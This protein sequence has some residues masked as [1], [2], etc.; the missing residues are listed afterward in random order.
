MF[1]TGHRCVLMDQGIPWT[2]M[3]DK[4]RFARE[5]SWSTRC[6]ANDVS[7][8]TIERLSKSPKRA[9]CDRIFPPE[10]IHI[11]PP[12]RRGGRGGLA[13]QIRQMMP[14]VEAE[15]QSDNF[16]P[17][18]GDTSHLHDLDKRLSEQTFSDFFDIEKDF[19]RKSRSK[20][21][22]YCDCWNKVENLVAN[23]KDPTIMGVY[24]RILP[25]ELLKRPKK[26]EPRGA[27]N[28][29]ARN[30]P[31]INIAKIKDFTETAKFEVEE[32]TDD[33]KEVEEDEVVDASDSADEA[34]LDYTTNYFDPGENYDEDDGGE[35][36]DE[37]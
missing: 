17:L 29:G 16:S 22:A 23:F 36:G 11:M 3:A 6:P 10:R 4:I 33:E 14:Q 34:D 20:K 25:K 8:M 24:E 26:T 5:T 27:R 12:K 31:R 2:Q 28:G 15:Q 13:S 21:D 30:G 9:S 35:Y 37:V 18:R 7:P 19:I 1:S 32:A